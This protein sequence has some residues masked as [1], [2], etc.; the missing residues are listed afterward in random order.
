[1][2]RD[3]TIDRIDSPIGTILVVASEDALV[4]L[5]FAAYEARLHALL[6][7]RG[8]G[9][10]LLK[11]RNPLGS[12]DRLDAYFGGDPAALDGL[13]VDPAGTDFQRAVWLAL[14]S[15]P[16]GQTSSYGALAAKLGKPTAGRAVGYANSLNPIAIALP[17]HR[18]IG[19]NGALTGYA[20]GLARKRW[21]LAHEG[22]VTGG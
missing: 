14:R 18:V 5:D 16:A 2:T 11:H 3:L 7:K 17:C 8:P 12:R 15:I 19:A 13:P 10:R 6:A 20:G 1:M 4:A 22:A 21:L 9:I